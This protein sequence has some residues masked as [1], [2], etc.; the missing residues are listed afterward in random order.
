MIHDVKQ[1]DRLERGELGVNVKG[2]ASIQQ[3]FNVSEKKKKV[4]VFGSRV[5]TG[6]LK[7]HLRYRIVRDDEIIHDKLTISSLKHLKKSLSTIEK[8]QECGVAFNEPTPDAQNGD[9]IECYEDV[10][11]V[12]YKFNF[13]SGV[14]KT[15]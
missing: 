8:G 2:E 14:T 12:E 5:I 7:S 11:E 1:K 15:Y 3:L 4:T 9:L 10:S 6:E 13:K